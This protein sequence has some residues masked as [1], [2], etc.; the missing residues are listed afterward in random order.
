[1]RF[2]HW[3]VLGLGLPGAAVGVWL[4]AAS[5]TGAHDE[6][7]HAVRSDGEHIHAPVPAG[8]ADVKAPLH[9]WTDAA[10]LRR[11]EA[12][13]EVK[14]AVCHGKQGDGDGPDATWLGPKIGSFRDRTMVAEMSDAYWFWRVTEGNLVEPYKSKGSVMPAYKDSLSTEDTRCWLRQPVG[15]PRPS[16]ATA[17]AV[18]VGR[19]A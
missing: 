17:R 3:R 8:Y 15:K 6:K 18:E 19:H 7:P 10:V 4:V 11:G 13:Y 12:I 2:D 16:L 9:I 14:C 5:Q 1:M